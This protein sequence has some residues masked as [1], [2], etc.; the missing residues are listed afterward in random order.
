MSPA[1]QSPGSYRCNTGFT[2]PSGYV[3]L[4]PA[5]MT[6]RSSSS[7]LVTSTG[8]KSV[9]GQSLSGHL[10]WIVGMFA[11]VSTR[12][13]TDPTGTMNATDLLGLSSGWGTADLG[14]SWHVDSVP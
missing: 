9:G 2:I 11:T 4:H 14:A 6:I 1:L 12:R 10:Y 8:S 5:Q 13:N 3:L 7:L